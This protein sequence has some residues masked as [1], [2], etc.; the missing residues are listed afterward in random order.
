[1]FSCFG[2]FKKRRHD[3]EEREPLLPRYRGDTALQARLREKLHSYQM[4]RALGKG[5]MPSNEQLITNLRTLLTADV[6]SPHAPENL[7]DSGHALVLNVRLLI[8]QFIELLQHKNADDQIQDFIWFLAKS[9]I[10]V[11]VHDVA[12]R[13]SRAKSKADTAA[14]K[15]QPLAPISLMDY[16]EAYIF[17]PAH[18]PTRAYRPSALCC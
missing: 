1:M 3:D 15:Y 9:R 11:D 6:L 7:S 12:E 8:T 13:A 10:S 16:F 17:P 2:L 5:Y 4:L 14:G 18:Q